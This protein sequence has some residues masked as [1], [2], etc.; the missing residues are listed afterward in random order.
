MVFISSLP[1][2]SA[3]GP[4]KRERLKS[5]KAVWRIRSALYCA[6]GARK[7]DMVGSGDM[8]GKV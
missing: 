8:E 1:V 5:Y 6:L 2:F 7:F 3:S 4:T